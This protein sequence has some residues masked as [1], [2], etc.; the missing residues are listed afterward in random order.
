MLNS[1]TATRP[2][3][4]AEITTELAA[5]RQKVDSLAEQIELQGNIQ[6]EIAKLLQTLQ[7]QQKYLPRLVEQIIEKTLGEK[8]KQGSSISNE[9]IGKL[10]D[11]IVGINQHLHA[12]KQVSNL[13]L[14]KIPSTESKIRCVFIVQSIPMWDALADVY[15]EMVK[16]ERFHPMI[17]S[18]NHSHLGRAEFSGEDIVHNWLEN[19][20]IPHIRLDVQSLE[21]LD[22]LRNLM[23][24]VVFRQQQWDIPVPPGLRT[25]EITFARICVVPYGMG[26]LAN[27]DAKDSSD[28]AYANNYDQIYHRSAWK[29]FC[30]T[31][32][33]QSYYR[34]FQHSD[35]DK[36]VLSGYSKFDK[37]RQY[38]GKGVWPLGESGARSF[39]VIWAPH[40]SLAIQ[41]QG[42]GVFHKIYRE[43]LD[44]ARSDESIQFVFKPHPA[45]EY[46]VRTTRPATGVD[47]DDFISKWT[48]LPNCG[49]CEGNYG[50]LFA[51]SDLMITDG[52]SFLTEY[53]IFE[54][55]LIF[56]DSCC[57]APFNELGR[58][59]EKC[60]DRVTTFDQLKSAALEYRSGKPFMFENERA[61]LLSLIFPR[62]EP[63]AQV[64]LNTI[65][66]DI[67]PLRS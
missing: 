12:I 35:P 15:M 56:I 40:F 62:D 42:F 23:P 50:E 18:I 63:A 17:V 39:R 34:S 22:I 55:P 52:V 25:S 14:R 29:V 64:I 8:A 3:S 65:A 48:S 46:A 26:V 44:W 54:K 21:A 11:D 43:M 6:V 38:K 16:D 7:S 2:D 5:L 33:T 30:E 61:Y 37:L 49:L 13:T 58:I 41:N 51:S 20:G 67:Y 1:D 4:V 27:P 24:D 36:F 57:H 19:Q 9:F 31:K 60:A 32:I 28:E 10:A 45:F 47:Y 66:S 53:H 59:S